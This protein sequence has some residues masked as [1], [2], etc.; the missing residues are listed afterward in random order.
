[1]DGDAA[2]L[3]KLGR[4][5]PAL[6]Q[7]LRA[8]TVRLSEKLVAAIREDYLAGRALHARSGKLAGAVSAHVRNEDDFV[9]AEIS[10]DLNA[11]KYGAFW[12]SGFMRAVGSG[13]RGGPR[14]LLARARARYTLKH[15]AGVKQFDARPFL[16]PA[17]ADLRE[18]IVAAL[19]DNG[20]DAAAGAMR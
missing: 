19:G 17:F 7:A 10:L 4:V 6:R 9:G 3:D 18:E 15:P 1:M 20:A 12:E 14:A 5:V 2:L 8:E 11:A 13:A 16:H